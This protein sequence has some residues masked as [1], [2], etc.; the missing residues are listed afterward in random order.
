MVD[1]TVELCTTVIMDFLQSSIHLV[2]GSCIYVDR[3][4]LLKMVAQ[5]LDYL[6]ALAS[7]F[8]VISL[9]IK[10]TACRI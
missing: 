10:D 8:L 9:S 2:W 7:F 1:F 6:F 3:D 5:V 4:N